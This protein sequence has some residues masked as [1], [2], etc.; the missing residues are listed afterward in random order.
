LCG[1]CCE[2]CAAASL[3]WVG[4]RKSIGSIL[5]EVEKDRQFYRKSGGGLTVS[6]GEPLM[7]PE[8]TYHL[9]DQAQKIGLHTAI[10]TCGFIQDQ[11]RLLGIASKSDL[12][13]FDLKAVERD[14]YLKYTAKE[15]DCVFR[16]LKLLLQSDFSIVL[17]CPV[18]PSINANPDYF[19]QVGQ[20]LDK[21]DKDK[22]I[23]EIHL[24]P[25]HHFGL[26]KYEA[27]NRPYRLQINPAD[28]GDMLK[29]KTTLNDWGYK[30]VVYPNQ[31]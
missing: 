8:F 27:L 25:Y 30:V 5:R 6:G 3:E 29:I 22:K 26:S 21:M 1:A 7:Q 17:R 11:E 18:I 2:V 10:E 28:A 15:S 9:L 20:F 14:A 31:V 16:N 12:I 4:E 19:E 23:K 24:L 13:L